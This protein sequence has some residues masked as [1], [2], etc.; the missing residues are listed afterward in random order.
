MAN[1]ESETRKAINGFYD[2]LLKETENAYKDFCISMKKIDTEKFEND[3]RVKNINE[4]FE[5]LKRDYPKLDLDLKCSLY[6]YGWNYNCEDTNEYEHYT[7]TKQEIINEKR[8][9]ILTLE[10]NSKKSEEYKKAINEFMK[11]LNKKEVIK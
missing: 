9:L 7:K 8:K 3:Y 11:K 4:L 6:K 1:L 5:K 2:D 10:T